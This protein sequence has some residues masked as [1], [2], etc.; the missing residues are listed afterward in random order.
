MLTGIS[1]VW[2]QASLNM[3]KQGHN[4][5]IANPFFLNGVVWIFVCLIYNL[6][7]SLL[8]PP[9][10]DGLHFFLLSSSLISII[11]GIITYKNNI[12]AFSPVKNFNIKYQWAWLAVLYLFLFIEFIAA[13]SFPL[14]GYL[15]GKVTVKYNE[16]GLPLI[17]VIL[18]NGLSALC[19]YAFYCFKSTHD[20]KKRKLLIYITLLSLFPFILIFNRGAIISNIIGIFIICFVTSPHP[21]KLAL[22]VTLFALGLLFCFGIMGNI[23]MGKNNTERLVQFVK[24]TKAFEES[25]IPNEF[26]WSYLYIA[27]PLANT[28]NTIDHVK[29]GVGD[30][31]DFHKMFVFEMI[32]EMIAKAFYGDTEQANRANRARLVNNS[33]TVSTVYGRAYNYMGWN[34]FWVLY[35]FILLFITI[36]IK[37]IPKSNKFHF[38]MIVSLNIIIILNLFD[39]MLVFMGLVPQLFIFLALYWCSLLSFKHIRST[40]HNKRL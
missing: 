8:C 7:W 13:G 35:A 6:R 5:L 30:S 4:L 16:F 11:I 10:S 20:K 23:R 40:S 28:Q 12:I 38:P 24:P 14:T 2:H 34:G 21:W 27:T 22:K 17:H 33:F 37:L 3:S 19:I 1:D 39:N 18:V 25:N 26:M 29:Q 36:N 31:D 9:I 32:P 15:S